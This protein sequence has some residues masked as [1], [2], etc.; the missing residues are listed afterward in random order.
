MSY[1]IALYVYYHGNNLGV[2]GIDKGARDADLN[3]QGMKRPEEINPQLVDNRL[4]ED[5]KVQVQKEAITSQEMNWN[6]MM[7]AAIQKSQQETYRMFQAKQVENT[8]FDHTAESLVEDFDEQ[9]SIGLDFFS[10]IN[11]VGA[12]SDGQYGGS[13]NL[14]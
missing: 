4:I 9:G 3:N 7:K 2:F 5:A 1:L 6:E 10:E 13:N 12:G 11:G 14:W 8:V